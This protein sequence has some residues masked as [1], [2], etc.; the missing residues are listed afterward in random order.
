MTKK[1]DV[2]HGFSSD[3][4]EVEITLHTQSLLLKALI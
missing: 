3:L 2:P 1:P 4:C